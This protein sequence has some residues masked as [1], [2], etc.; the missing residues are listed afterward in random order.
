MLTWNLESEI[1]NIFTN[2]S[3]VTLYI[4]C[5]KLKVQAL[6]D[7]DITIKNI[8]TSTTLNKTSNESIVKVLKSKGLDIEK[9]VNGFMKM[10]IKIN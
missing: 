3:I 4:P 5:K 6:E 8:A 9:Y 7:E 2:N 10:Q 1:Y